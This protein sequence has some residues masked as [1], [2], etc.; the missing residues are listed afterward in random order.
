[1]FDNLRLKRW[2]KKYIYSGTIQYHNIIIEQAERHQE[3][4]EKMYKKIELDDLKLRI[5]MLESQVKEFIDAH[6]TTWY[7]QRIPDIIVGEKE[8]PNKKKRR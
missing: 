4:Q 2:K 6:V 3:Y 5:C 1:M 8:T 7:N